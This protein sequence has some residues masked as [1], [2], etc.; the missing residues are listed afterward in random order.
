M[1]TA[2]QT[3]KEIENFCDMGKFEN[4]LDVVNLYHVKRCRKNNCGTC[5][6]ICNLRYLYIENVLNKTLDVENLKKYCRNDHDFF[7]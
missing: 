5:N 2:V 6:F 1:E 4:F 3:E 7:M